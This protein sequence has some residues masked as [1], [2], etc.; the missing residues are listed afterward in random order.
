MLVDKGRPVRPAI[1]IVLS[2]DAGHSMTCRTR[3]QIFQYP[4]RYA[5]TTMCPSRLRTRWLWYT[6][7][8]VVIARVSAALHQGERPEA[9]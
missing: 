9:A 1:T 7:W 6:A 4:C 8:A 5:M 3:P 2:Y